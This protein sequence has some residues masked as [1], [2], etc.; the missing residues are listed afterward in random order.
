MKIIHHAPIATPESYLIL[1]NQLPVAEAA[2]CLAK[3]AGLPRAS[4][5][6]IVKID[7]P[8]VQFN[9]NI[10]AFVLGP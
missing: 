7:D 6:K 8:G 4:C 2:L 5:L 3:R 10:F 1:L 9:I